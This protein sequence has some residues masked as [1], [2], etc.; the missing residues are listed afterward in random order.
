MFVAIRRATMMVVIVV[1]MVLSLMM[2]T[3]GCCVDSGGVRLGVVAAA[4]GRGAG[5]R[6]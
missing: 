5:R 6:V 3:V 1:V 4:T 2:V